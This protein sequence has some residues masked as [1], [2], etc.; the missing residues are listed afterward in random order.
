MAS[1]P[2]HA[3]SSL[4]I[5]S[6]KKQIEININNIAQVSNEKKKMAEPTDTSLPL[7]QALHQSYYRVKVTEEFS[8]RMS[9]NKKYENYF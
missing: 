9:I 3:N 2:D 8:I 6:K 5:I 4:K 1:I 7:R